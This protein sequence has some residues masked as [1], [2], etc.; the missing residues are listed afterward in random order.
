MHRTGAR[1]TSLTLL[2]PLV[3]AVGCGAPAVQFF[4]DGADAATDATVDDGGAEGMADVSPE[5][6]PD[7]GSPPDGPPGS[8]ADRGPY[9]FGKGPPPGGKCC[10]NGGGP[11]FG[12]CNNHS[13]AACGACAWPLVCCTQGPN[14]SCAADPCAHAD[15]A[16]DA[17]DAGDAVADVAASDAGD[18]GG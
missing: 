17:A 6:T 15:A 4:D 3:T 9:C 7:A 10:P 5:V 2:A 11:C 16:A 14:G 8:D 18:A 1:S 13:C 12:T